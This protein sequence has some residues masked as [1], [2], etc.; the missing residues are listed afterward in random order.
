MTAEAPTLFDGL[1]VVPP[2]HSTFGTD[3]PRT[4]RTDPIYAHLGAD[5][6]QDS[7]SA[8]KK[9]VLEIVRAHGVVGG[10]QINAYYRDLF[11]T[12]GWPAVHPDSPRKRASELAEAGAL[13]ITNDERP[14]GTEAEYAI[15]TDVLEVAA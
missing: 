6:S 7:L 15:P 14:R 5:R 12:N 10:S 1:T 2:I 4:R 3:T 9:A 13:V 8:V 11:R